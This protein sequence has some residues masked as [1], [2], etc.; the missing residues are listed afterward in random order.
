MFATKPQPAVVKTDEHWHRWTTKTGFSRNT[1]WHHVAVSYKFGD[2]KSIKGWIDG[3][4]TEGA[5]DMGG[6]TAEAPVVDDDAI[7]IGSS[8]GGSATNSFRGTLDGIAIHR[9]LVSDAVMK[10]RFKRVGGAVVAKPAP[11][12]APEVGPIPEGKVLATFHEGLEAH[13]RWLNVDE[14][15]PP[16]TARWNRDRLWSPDGCAWT[17]VWPRWCFTA[18]PGW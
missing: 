5:W 4:L 12:V 11:E 8:M 7:W 14:S 16:E 2:P 17:R 13:N 9:E 18:V 10:T 15:V 3:V 1:G 6:A